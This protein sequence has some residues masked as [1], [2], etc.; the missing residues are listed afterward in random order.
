[1]LLGNPARDRKS[2]S[3]AARRI[4]AARPRGIDAIEA[5]EH[6]VLMLLRNADAVVGKRQNHLARAAAQLDRDASALGRILHAVFEDDAHHV[7]DEQRIGIDRARLVCEKLDL[8][9]RRDERHLLHD[10]LDQWRELQPLLAHGE[11]LLIGACE[12]QELLDQP[13]HVLGFRVYGAQSLFERLGVA[14]APAAQHVR[15]AADDRHGRPQLVRGV[16]YEAPL[17]LESR[18]YALK[19]VIER[20]SKLGKLVLDRR[21]GDAPPEVSDLKG[22]RRLRHRAN[23]PQDAATDEVAGSE[24][25]NDAREK[26][27]T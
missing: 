7:L 11:P 27:S 26:C 13:L 21:H 5:L 22:A 20:L 23:R 4:L 18:L 3:R 14:C 12:E 6:L 17:L 19:H 2:E 8:V 10:I 25:Q 15:I 24:R 1:M 16:G 9:P